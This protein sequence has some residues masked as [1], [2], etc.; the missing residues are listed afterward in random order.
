MRCFIA[1]PLDQ[2]IKSVLQQAQ[3]PFL[4]NRQRGNFT[5][6]D[7]FHLT[8]VFNGELN[9]QELAQIKGILDELEL[10]PFELTLSELGCFNR[11]DG[12]IWWVGV[13]ATPPLMKLQAQ[14]VSALRELELPFEDQR[15]VP[16]LT[17]VRNYKPRQ[18]GTPIVLSR[19]EP[20]SMIVKRV[21]LM[22]SQ[23]IQDKL[24]YTEIDWKE[25]VA[26]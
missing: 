2:S 5:T 17:L 3:A 19:S 12:E 13:K 15:Y 11:R 21:S 14:L 18:D 10:Q 20:I 9:Q 23:R 24:R 1:I 7:N 22:K 4:L 6:V 25:L 26:S 8:L 16:H